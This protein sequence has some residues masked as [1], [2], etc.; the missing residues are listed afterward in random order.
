MGLAESVAHRLTQGRHVGGIVLVV[1]EAGE[2]HP[3]KPAE[4]A[5]QMPGADLVA[6]V[7]GIGDAVGEK[8]DVAHQPSPRAMV[9]PSRLASH[10][11]R[12]FHAST[13]SR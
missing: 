5:E 1:G 13:W 4:V 9:G 10:S 6:A 11:G 7:R 2:V 8:Q 12:R 3:G